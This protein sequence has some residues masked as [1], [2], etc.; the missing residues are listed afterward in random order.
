MPAAKEAIRASFLKLLEERPLREITV[1]DIVQDCGVN[2][3]SFYYHYKDIPSL[4]QDIAAAWAN[5]LL[6]E[7]SPVLSLADCLENAARFALAHRQIL[8]HINQSAHRDAFERHLMEF[9][10][11]V[12]QSWGEAAYGSIAVGREDREILL[13]FYQCACFGQIVDWLNEG[14]HYDLPGQFRR[15]CQ[16]GAGMTEALLRRAA[17]EGWAAGTQNRPQA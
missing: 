14:M 3:N 9:C 8:L 2:R 17:G 10:R 15:L 6:A 12:V 5:R 7:Q 16:L 1:K 4:L 13:R 11:Q